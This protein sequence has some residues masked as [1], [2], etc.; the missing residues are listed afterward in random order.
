MEIMLI[1]DQWTRHS[2]VC[3]ALCV[4]GGDGGGDDAGGRG[5]DKYAPAPLT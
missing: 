3:L 4:V 1:R 2:D 5:E